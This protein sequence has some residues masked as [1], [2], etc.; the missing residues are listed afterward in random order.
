MRKR[1]AFLT[2]IPLILSGCSITFGS[3]DPTSIS[4]TRSEVTID[5]GERDRL[6]YLIEPSNA[7]KTVTWSMSVENIIDIDNNGYIT[8]LHA[9]GTTVTVTTTN[10]LSDSCYVKVLSTAPVPATG[11]N[12]N[13]PSAKLSIG[14]KLQLTPTLSPKN[15]ISETYSWSTDDDS[16]ASVDS[17][18]L[19]TANDIGEA[20]IT[21]TTNTTGLTATCQITVSDNS[22][23]WDS[24]QD[25]LR[26]GTKRLDFYSLNDTHG[27]V[28][29][30]GSEPGLAKLSTYIKNKF[31]TNPSGSVFTSSGDMWQG[32]ADSNITRGKL[33]IDWLNYLGCSAQ[34]IGNH[35]FD[36]TIDTIKTNQQRMNF[37]ML[38]CNVVNKNTYEPVDWLEP[39]TTITRNGVHIGIVGAIGK[40]QTS[41]ILASNVQDL[42]FIDPTENAL[43]WINYLKDNGAD[44]V[45]FVIHDSIARV[46]SSIYE[47]AD[48]IFGAH[49]HQGETDMVSGTPAIQATSNGKNLGYISL[50]YAFGTQ[51]KSVID[52]GYNNNSEIL[53]CSEDSGTLALWGP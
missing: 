13:T 43:H 46:N 41:D 44:V 27:S 42:T 5:E 51:T 52:Y 45:L 16:V 35:E 14:Q 50:N 3:K 17:S 23:M 39:Y 22:S 15:A 47:A 11:V 34:A 19:V 10:N 21:C 1:F 24:S 18:G 53:E 38:A 8:G 12:L 30:S 7:V 49:T 26:T 2:V 32:S 20:T 28:N 48:A 4:F 31:A 25:S 6:T 33:V 29:E 40:G 9:G 36:W 37:P